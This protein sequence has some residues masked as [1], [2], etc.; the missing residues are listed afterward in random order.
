M[1]D[2]G[3]SDSETAYASP[4]ARVDTSDDERDDGIRARDDERTDDD[5]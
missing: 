1:Y 5:G 2:D 4:R 3:A